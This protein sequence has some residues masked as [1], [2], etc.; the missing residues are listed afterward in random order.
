[1]QVTTVSEDSI[2][3]AKISLGLIP[4][5]SA[6][7][8]STLEKAM[9]KDEIDKMKAE[10][11]DCLK[12]G[13][14]YMKKAEE[15]KAKL[16]TVT[17]GETE[18]GVTQGQQMPNVGTV[19]QKFDKAETQELVKA[20]VAEIVKGYDSKFESLKTLLV[21]KEQEND[22][23]KKSI[24]DLTSTVNSLVKANPGPRSLTVTS[25]T[26]RFAKPQ[27]GEIE[28]SLSRNKKQVVAELVKAAGTDFSENNIFAKAASTV[29]I[30]GALGADQQEASLVAREL[31]RLHKVI[32]TG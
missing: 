25:F 16:A 29:E 27:D 7:P 15:M 22:Q 11:D 30:A 8:D 20:E 26:E 1:M 17:Q 2:L 24:E 10:M 32:I 4:D 14:E 19:V 9:S 31:R 6:A 23:L 28:L 18:G 13:S 3:K 12:K 21:G 5:P